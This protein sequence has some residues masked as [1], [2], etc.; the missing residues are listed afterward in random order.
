MKI[1]FSILFW[2]LSSLAT[3]QTTDHTL[4][5]AERNFSK[6][7]SL[8]IERKYEEASAV[9]FGAQ[10]L[11]EDVFGSE[12]AEYGVALGRAAEYEFWN[13]NRWKP[14]LLKG[15]YIV[16]RAKGSRCDEYARLLTIYARYASNYDD[17]LR[18]MDFARQAVDIRREVLGTE[19]PDYAWSLTTLGDCLYDAYHYDDAIP[20]FNEA[21]VV[22]RK[23]E[24]THWRQL[25][26]VLDLLYKACRNSGRHDEGIAALA[27]LL[28]V[29]TRV[30]GRCDTETMATMRDLTDYYSEQGRKLEAH[31]LQEELN[32]LANQ[33]KGQHNEL[34]FVKHLARLASSH[35]NHGRYDLAIP[36]CNQ[37]VSIYEKDM[38]KLKGSLIDSMRIAEVTTRLAVLYEKVGHY[39]SAI[40]AANKAAG[41]WKNMRLN[42]DTTYV[43]LINR[44]ALCYYRMEMY[45]KTIA[46]AKY[47]IGILDANPEMG[48]MNQTYVDALRILSWSEAEEGLVDEAEQHA[49]R[50]LDILEQTG[51]QNTKIYAYCQY[52]LAKR[53]L[54]TDEADK[55]PPLYEAA[56]SHMK[57][58]VLNNFSSQSAQ[59]RQVTWNGLQ[60]IFHDSYPQFCITYHL[61][62]KHIK[63]ASAL[64]D[65]SALFAKGLMLTAET[66][67][68]EQV[69]RTGDV[70][71]MARL[72]TLQAMRTQLT[73]LYD[74]PS[75]QQASQAVELS[76]QIEYR[77]KEL[78]LM[79]KNTGKDY[80]EL[81]QTSWRDVQKALGPEDI[82]VE[83]VTA[84]LKNLDIDA[85]IALTLRYDDPY[86]K[87]KLVFDSW[88]LSNID[89]GNI[90]EDPTLCDI[91]WGPL[92]DRFNGIRNIY[93]APSGPLHNLGIENLPGCENF[94]FYR[95]SSTRELVR[96]Q[97][98]KDTRNTV[99]YGGLY[100]DTDLADMQSESQAYK[101][102]MP[103]ASTSYNSRSIIDSLRVRGASEGTRYLEG[104]ATEVEAIAQLAKSKRIKTTTL[105]GVKGN[106]ESFKALSGKNI[107]VV[108]IATHGFYWTEETVKASEQND[109]GDEM[110]R[111]NTEDK[112]LSRSGLL[113]AG[114]DNALEGE[115]P[116]DIEDGILTA[117]EIAQLDLS[118]LDMTVLSACETALGDVSKS[119]GIYGLQRGFK[120]AGANSI[121]MSLWKVDDEATCMLMTEFYKF[122]LSG[123]TKHDALELAKDV[124][125]SHQE[126]GWD[127]PKYWAAFI[128]LDGLN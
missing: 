6:A 95:L 124:V 65:Y 20:L 23:Y 51:K 113:M 127:D 77:E 16:S 76:Q 81:L 33:A 86:P 1:S 88:G 66:G 36:L 56:L 4:P 99:L 14:N 70:A 44:I 123:E 52:E 78:V 61:T 10:L 92:V 71:L 19:H 117:Q 57:Q 47:G 115:V 50:A 63:D 79:L 118:N 94:N 90:Y 22:L 58:I 108:H 103:L 80:T 11:Y 104:T 111:R 74:H 43:E 75:A 72:D 91:V 109:L 41:I 114:A 55:A 9:A 8:R 17:S 60:L 106:E 89:L 68:N 69:R 38:E 40:N 18:R 49:R 24:A 48:C 7:D 84:H 67:L 122:W 29:E 27:E 101:Q 53:M 73:N 37:I 46:Y 30:L 34:Y 105:T 59:E 21:V 5:E 126:K 39:I 107:Q 100:Y 98:Q 121:L 96:R 110:P 28:E 32:Q 54:Y 112:A 45:K 82:A 64:Y 3:A 83:F 35:E 125:R 120:K 25:G 128:M 2:G 93:F 42:N 102:D 12:S 119:E 13:G 87:M 85:T 26:N 62:K 116:D 31:R 97:Q 15:I